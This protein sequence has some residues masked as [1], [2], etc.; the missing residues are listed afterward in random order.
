MPRFIKAI[1]SSL[2]AAA[3]IFLP[4]LNQGNKP[5]NK[6]FNALFNFSAQADSIAFNSEVD[7]IYDSLQLRKKGLRKDAFK[8]AYT[9]YTKLVE[10]GK[11]N[12]EGIITICDMS[13]SSR[14]KRLYVIDLDQYK[15]LLNTYVAHGKNSGAEYA[16][17]FSNR[18]ES[19]QSSLGFYKTKTT[20]WGGHGLSL[21][22]SGLE[23]GFNDKAERRKIVIHGSQYIGDNYRRWGKYMGRSFGCPAVPI[24]QSKL[25]IN[26]IKNGSCLFIYHPTKNYLT[27]S[28]ILNG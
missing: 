22:L 13:Q 7:L 18:P 23:P 9:G 26:T 5:I 19:L 28:K 8:Y 2:P 16:R 14:R 20:Y 25:L 6:K 10:E 12:K 17:K 15:L 3:F 4:L 21:T 11:I 1:L 24:K 27:A